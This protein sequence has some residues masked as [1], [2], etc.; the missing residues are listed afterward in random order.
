[1]TLRHMKALFTQICPV[2]CSHYSHTLP[3]LCMP[4]ALMDVLTQD[5]P[6]QAFRSKKPEAT[7]SHTLKISSH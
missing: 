6:S 1:M 5:N 4:Y 7:S 2:S 3:K